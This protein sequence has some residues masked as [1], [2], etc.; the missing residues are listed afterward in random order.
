MIKKIKNT[1]LVGWKEWFNLDF[2]GLPAIKGK[3]DTGAKTSVLHAFNIENFFRSSLKLIIKIA[4][5]SQI[6]DATIVHYEK[7]KKWFMYRKVVQKIKA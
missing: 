1:F 6:F 5:I 4:N 2:L 3:I 7:Q